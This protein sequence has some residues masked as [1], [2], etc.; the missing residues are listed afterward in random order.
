MFL[1]LAKE[2]F[3]LIILLI[4]ITSASV[5]P[6]AVEVQ[7][8]KRRVPYKIQ[9]DRSGTGYFY[10]S[11][12]EERIK[13][14]K[15]WNGGLNGKILVKKAGD[16]ALQAWSVVIQLDTEVDKLQAYDSK[17]DKLDDRT[18]KISPL[19]WNSEIKEQAEKNVNVQVWWKAGEAEPRIRYFMY[20]LLLSYFCYASITHWYFIRC[21]VLLQCIHTC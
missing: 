17:T 7:G 14:W 10:S 21:N 15:G 18:Y 11:G 1:G 12:C 13:S 20:R 6:T 16:P 4:Y 3:A 8:N 9:I 19:S 2:S 5:V